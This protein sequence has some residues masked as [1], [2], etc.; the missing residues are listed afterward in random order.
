MLKDSELGIAMNV[1]KF[2][3][4]TNS[5]LFCDT[6][7]WKKYENGHCSEVEF[8]LTNSPLFFHENECCLAIIYLKL[9]LICD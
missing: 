3:G 9:P 7:T 8:Y 4:E 5:D 1:S 6:R 2:S